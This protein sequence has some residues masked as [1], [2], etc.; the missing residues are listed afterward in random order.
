[1]PRV[2]C[3]WYYQ[4]YSA[5]SNHPLQPTPFLFFSIP[6][7]LPISP[8][9][10]SEYDRYWIFM[11]LGTNNQRRSLNVPHFLFLFP[12]GR[13]FSITRSLTHRQIT[14]CHFTTSSISW[15][16][17]TFYLKSH[18]V[19]KQYDRFLCTKLPISL[20]YYFVTR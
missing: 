16:L 5:D 19:T 2:R 6:S 12:F 3:M 1:M 13:S 8:S 20:S 4:F 10:Y 7:S 18:L 11:R 9:P 14:T 17:M 15:P